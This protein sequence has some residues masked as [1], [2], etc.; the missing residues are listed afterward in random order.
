MIFDAFFDHRRSPS[1][2]DPDRPIATGGLTGDEPVLV[3]SKSVIGNANPTVTLTSAPT[4]GN[5]LVALG[6]HW[7]NAVSGINGWTLHTNIPGSVNAGIMVGY[8]IALPGESATQTPFSTGAAAQTMTVFEVSGAQSI[9]L[10][11][12]LKEVSTNPMTL[13]GYLSRTDLLL[14]Q[15]MQSTDSSAF[16]LSGD[17]TTPL[18]NITG[19]PG[20][21]GPYRTQSFAIAPTDETASITV[22]T[23]ASSSRSSII[24]VRVSSLAADRGTVVIS[25]FASYIGM[26]PRTPV[27]NF[28]F[29]AEMIAV[30]GTPGIG[31]VDWNYAIAGAWQALGQGTLNVVYNTNGQVRFNNTTLA[32][33]AAYG[34]GDRICVAVD[35]PNELIWFKVNGG[36]WN[37][38]GTADPV[39]RVN[40]ISFAAMTGLELFPALSFSVAGTVVR[41]AMEPGDF[42][43]TQPTGYFAP[44][45]VVVDLAQQA[46]DPTSP[47]LGIST[48][49]ENDDIIYM[50]PDLAYGLRPTVPAGPVKVLAGEVRENDIGVERRLVR[51][52]NK[53]TGD[54]IGEFRTAPDGS[55]I[56]PV[57]DGAAPHYVVAFDD[58]AGDDYNAKIY[59]NVLPG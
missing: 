1:T 58:E 25:G 34:A 40:G 42:V 8:K 49:M 44:S 28:Y 10:M 57:Q 15:V 20:Q 39:T 51:V 31:I 27:G 46:S 59:D 50:V 56:I 16:S 14:G 32:T 9:S 53:A 18:D 26:F 24:G 11:S 3:Q 22:T 54:L 35:V 41:T 12:Y 45:E 43:Y 48:T 37:N 52:Y 6:T 13:T 47:A 2:T 4:A 5:L 38:D 55:F 7:N 21:D 36:S 30:A 17:T 23:T 19:N 29:E 33:I